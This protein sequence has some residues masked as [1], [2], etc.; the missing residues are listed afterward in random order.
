MTNDSPILSLKISNGV[1]YPNNFL[2]QLFI[3]IFIHLILASVTVD[4]LTSFGRKRLI[5]PLWFSLVPLSHKE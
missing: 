5:M 1:L 4:I 3:P 2:G